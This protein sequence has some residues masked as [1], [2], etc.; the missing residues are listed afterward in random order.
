MIKNCHV[1][2]ENENQCGNS[3]TNPRR[4]RYQIIFCSK[5]IGHSVQNFYMPSV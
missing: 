3:Q 5:Y 4:A 1:I 2:E